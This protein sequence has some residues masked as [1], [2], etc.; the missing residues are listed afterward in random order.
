MSKLIDSLEKVGQ[1][2]P[3]S[4]G[5]GAISRS[6]RSVPEIVLI[7]QV[8]GDQ[9]IN[10]RS[11]LEAEVDG[12]LVVLES[13][14]KRSLDRIRSALKGRT[15]GAR[16][17]SID[18]SHAKDLKDRGCDFIVFKADDTS[19]AVLNDDELG[20]I[21]AIDSKLSGREAR[22][23]QE[24]SIDGVLLEPGDD[25]IPLTVRKLLNIQQGR[26]RIDKPLL[27]GTSS[28]LGAADLEVFRNAGIQGLVV[29]LASPDAIARTRDAISGL[30]RRRSRTRSSDAAVPRVAAGF[31]AAVPGDDED[32]DVGI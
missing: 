11:L 28:E 16:A 20:K 9:L 19:A 30:P 17:D 25:L 27:V 1:Y 12:V 15:W 23:I 24:L 26:G 10:D 2:A 22:A 6:D 3:S 21:I 4:M 8:A 5:F 7:G 31:G 13:W 32:D 29:D 14:T 18:E